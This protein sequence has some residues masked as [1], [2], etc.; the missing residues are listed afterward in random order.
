[1]DSSDRESFM[2]AVIEVYSSTGAHDRG[3]RDL[4]IQLTT[5]SLRLL[6][7]SDSPVFDRTFLELV[8]DF[9]LE[10]GLS[11]TQR[12]AEYQKKYQR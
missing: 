6:R 9:L 8:P 3:L 5:Y 11:A 7:D 4:V 10:I 12:C 2:S 1:M